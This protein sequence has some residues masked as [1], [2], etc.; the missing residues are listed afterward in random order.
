[1]LKLLTFSTAKSTFRVNWDNTPLPLQ[2]QCWCWLAV[3][4]VPRHYVTDYV[5]A[6]LS[7]SRI[8]ARVQDIKMCIS[9][10]PPV[11]ASTDGKQKLFVGCCFVTST[12]PFDLK[13]ALHAALLFSLDIL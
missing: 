9:P 7:V 10:F 4:R 11:A 2:F 1:M 3:V 8:E 5:A 13:M 12:A 6:G